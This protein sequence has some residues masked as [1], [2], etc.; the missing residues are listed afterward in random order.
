MVSFTSGFVVEVAEQ[1]KADGDDDAEG[2]GDDQDLDQLHGAGVKGLLNGELVR[3]ERLQVMDLTDRVPA[4]G[5][6]DDD[7]DYDCGNEESPADLTHGQKPLC[8]VF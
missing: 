8:L 2:Q 7:G 1:I 5:R 4:D 3:I 6:D